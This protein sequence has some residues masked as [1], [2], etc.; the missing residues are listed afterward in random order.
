MIKNFAKLTTVSI[1]ALLLSGCFSASSVNRDMQAPVVEK[2]P[3]AVKEYVLSGDFLFDFD[4]S[5]L[6]KQGKSTLDRIAQ[7]VNH[8]ELTVLL[9]P[10][11]QTV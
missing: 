3:V 2:T 1:S 5:N 8:Q 9:L 4:K 7:E 6:T 10:V 11:I